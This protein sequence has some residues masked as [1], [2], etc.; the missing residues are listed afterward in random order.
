MQEKISLSSAKEIY[1]NYIYKCNQ[2][3]DK[4]SLWWYLPSSSR[5]RIGTD[6]Q[7]KFIESIFQKKSHKVEQ[8]GIRG[9]F[10]RFPFFKSLLVLI[11]DTIYILNIIIKNKKLT[12]KVD[13]LFIMPLHNLP[14]RKAGNK[15]WNHYFGEL[16]EEFLKLDLKVEVTGVVDPELYS[17]D[18]IFSEK[19][20]RI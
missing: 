7:E 11:R 1:I 6:V 9:F 18:I 16:P 19:D 3:F 8:Y 10:N 4:S 20:Y 5:E 14:V 12:R 2:K 17:K 15:I 13:I